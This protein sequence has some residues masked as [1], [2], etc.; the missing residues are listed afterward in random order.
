MTIA[1]CPPLTLGSVSAV[2]SLNG[3]SYGL[4]E[5]VLGFYNLGLKVVRHAKIDYGD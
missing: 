1:A 3:V 2:F 5:Q 4:S